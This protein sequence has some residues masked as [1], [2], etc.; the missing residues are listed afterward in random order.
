MSGDALRFADLEDAYDNVTKKT[1]QQ[2][3]VGVR[4]R[5]DMQWGSK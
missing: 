3:L 2:P 4:Y 5:N 1:A